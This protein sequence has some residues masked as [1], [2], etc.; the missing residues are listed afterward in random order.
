MSADIFAPVLQYKQEDKLQIKE[1]K[2]F[3][4]IQDNQ[5]ETSLKIQVIN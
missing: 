5:D 1:E 3:L 4:F 2:E